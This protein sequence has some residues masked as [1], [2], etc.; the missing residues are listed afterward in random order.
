MNRCF[1]PP[2]GICC[3]YRRGQINAFL[4]SP[5][6]SLGFQP[7]AFMR[8]EREKK[9]GRDREPNPPFLSAH[10]T[11]TRAHL[12]CR[13]LLPRFFDR[14]SRATKISY[15][16]FSLL[17]D[18][19]SCSFGGKIEDRASVQ[20]RFRPFVRS[21]S[22]LFRSS[23]FPFSLSLSLGL[24]A[25]YAPVSRSVD[26]IGK[27]ELPLEAKLVSQLTRTWHVAVHRSHGCTRIQPLAEY[28]YREATKR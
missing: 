10:A 9:R 26:K 23:R 20:L 7:Q 21:C 3:L 15:A 5:S 1:S 8:K 24:V 2:V 14:R 13:H 19:S 18:R 4:F 16:N 12:A 6:P 25:A 22:G 28:I 27:G 17:G 11:R